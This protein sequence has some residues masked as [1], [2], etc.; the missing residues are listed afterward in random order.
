MLNSPRH[1]NRTRVSPVCA[2]ARG[3]SA[4]ALGTLAIGGGRLWRDRLTLALMSADVEFATVS[5]TESNRP[6]R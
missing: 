6:L 2:L 1:S 4:S 3:V 5:A